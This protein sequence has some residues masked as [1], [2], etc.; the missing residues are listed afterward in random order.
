MKAYRAAL[1]RFDDDHQ[2][3]YEQDGLLVVGPDAQGRQ[4]VRA[5]GSFDALKDRF[6]GVTTE[7]LPG[8]LIAPGFVDLHIHYPQTDVIGSPAEGRC[9]GW[10]TTP[11]PTSRAFMTRPTPPRWRAFS[12]TNWPATASPHR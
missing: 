3:L 6:P 4:V 7:H 8:R 12:S 1:L 11:F 10:K 5:A 9:P 2:P